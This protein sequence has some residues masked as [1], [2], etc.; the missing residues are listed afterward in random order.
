LWGEDLTPLEHFLRWLLIVFVGALGYLLLW[1][2]AP[3]SAYG[4]FGLILHMSMALAVFGPILVGR[5][6]RLRYGS[7][8][9]LAI[10]FVYGVAQVPGYYLFIE[11]QK[12]AISENTFE[13]LLAAT[14][15]I[16][17]LAVSYHFGLK[18]HSTH[19]LLKTEALNS[20]ASRPP[21]VWLVGMGVSFVVGI[22]VIGAGLR[23]PELDGH[24]II[25]LLVG[26]SAGLGIIYYLLGLYSSFQKK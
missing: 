13:P 1:R 6:F 14:K 15:L 9:V 2:L 5:A 22:A 8:L 4:H 19:T 3:A 10:G 12:L 25:E 11:R 18:P 24:Q 21:V 26:I 20:V 7:N 16:W 23:G 17:G